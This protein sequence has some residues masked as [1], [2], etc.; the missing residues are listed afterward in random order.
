MTAYN[1]DHYPW[2]HPLLD[3]LLRV[4]LIAV[5]AVFCYGIFHPFLSLMLWSVILAV[6]LYPL[7]RKL[8]A[9]LGKDG[10]TATVI[11]LVAI[12]ALAVPAWVIG[13]SLIGSAA[14]GLK[15]VRAQGAQ[16]PPPKA[17]VAEWPVVGPRVYATWQR[18]Y[19]HPE[20]LK[21]KLG[22][23]LKDAAIAGL[24]ALK[25]IA[26]G[27][28][29][30]LVAMPIA[31]IIMAFGEHAA[32]S[33]RRIC[34]AFVGPVRGPSMA[35]LCT[36]TVRAVAQGVIGIAFIQAVLIGIAIVPMGIP[37]A[38][39][40]CLA[41]LMLG[42]MQLPATILTIPIIIYVFATEGSSGINI[43]FAIYVFIAGLADN[44]LKPLL[45]GRGVAV[46]MPVVLIGAIGGMVTNGL[47]G[48][49]IGPVALGVAYELFWRWVDER[50][51]EAPA[52]APAPTELP[53]KP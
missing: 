32:E 41:I 52:E 13:D 31:G 49:F 14:E 44:V 5:L 34:S 16:V 50:V 46:P 17:S 1:P 38:G 39:L 37:G 25:N 7:H 28:L 9:K 33:A 10:R 27:L 30:F 3:V 42:I 6:T 2:A 45:L 43:I 21:E 35:A 53:H 19:E 18:A 23:K 20:E 8:R 4:G 24:G 51:P 11:V 29:L 48:L 40:M 36:S 15:V 47:L 26:A 12:L 22:P